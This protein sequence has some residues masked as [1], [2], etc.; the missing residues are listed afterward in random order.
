M[1]I[2]IT[3]KIT[4]Y[5][6]STLLLTFFL[7]TILFIYLSFNLNNKPVDLIKKISIATQNSNQ[8]YQYNFII[9]GY[10]YRQDQFESELNTDTIILA[11][12]QTVNHT[13]KLI[14]LPRDLWDY[15]TQQKINRFYQN[16]L[17]TNLP[18]TNTKNEFSRLTGQSINKILVL[19]TQ[20]IIELT[21]LIGGVDVYLEKGFIDD[22]YPNQAYIDNPQSGDPIYQTIEFP[23]GNIH[24][25]SDNVTQFIRSRKSTDDLDRI[26]RQQL[27]IEALIQKLKSTS[28][29][30]KPQ[31]LI[32]L[33]LYWQNS[34]QTDFT[35]QDL[36][37]VAFKL[38]TNLPNLNISRHQLT[39]GN[40]SGEGDIY[41]PNN[42]INQQWVF[43]PSTSDYSSFKDTI[44]TFLSK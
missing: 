4:I 38:K 2:K 39:V 12:Y 7:A 3:K 10:D 26:N 36:L 8:N 29:L 41:H 34:I 18:I 33:Y 32:N 28:F 43:I 30:S 25:D 40:K 13:L 5:L 6:L 31:N 14:S 1:K 37:N 9:L 22:Q 11:N 19:S 44:S 42:F 21:N 20:N 24:L 27:L 23:Q 16:A 15:Q 17:L 35:D